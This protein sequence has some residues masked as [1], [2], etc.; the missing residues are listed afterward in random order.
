MKNPPVLAGRF[1]GLLTLATLAT[2]ALVGPA[3]RALAD[4]ELWTGLPGTSVTTNWSDPLNFSGTSKNPNNNTVYF[5]NG[6][7]VAAGVINNVVDKSTNCYAL[8]FTNSTG[9][10]NTLI[11]AGQTLTLDGNNGGPALTFIPG[12][13]TSNTN[14]ISGATGTLLIT[15]SSAGGVTVVTTNSGAAGVAPILDLSGLGTL[16]ISNADTSAALAVG[17]GTVRSGG[18]LKLAQTNYLVLPAVGSVEGNASAIVVGYNSSN[19]GSSPG[20]QLLLGQANQI[21]AGNLGIG[22]SKQGTAILAFNPAFTNNNPTLTLRAVGGGAVTNWA[23]ADGINTSGTSTGPGGTVSFVG[24]TVNALVNA[25][26]LAKPS[27]TSA[28]A[29]SATGSLSFGAGLINVNLLTNGCAQAPTTGGPGKATATI[30]VN[31][32]GSL[33]VNNNL[34][35]AYLAT[36]A[37]SST[38]TLNIS[39]NGVVQANAITP[40]GGNST[41]NLVG[42]ILIVSNSLG[43]AAAPLT[44][45][46]LSNSILTF[47]V[48]NGTASA[49]V[50]TLNINGTAD[51]LNIAA[52]PVTAAFPA[53]YPVIQY[54]GGFGGQTATYD[55][56]LGTLP[57]TYQGY[58]S[59]NVANASVDLVVTNATQKLDTWNGNVNGNWDATTLN[60]LYSGN[61]VNYQA[62]D[63]VSFSD[64]AAGTPNVVLTTNLAPGDIAANNSAKNYVFSGPGELSGPTSLAKNGTGSL[65]LAETG[66][67]SFTGGIVVNNGTLVLDDTGST[68]SGGLTLNGGTV[69][70]GNNDANG[71]LP[72]G[73]V[74][75]NGALIFNQTSTS[76]ISALITGSGTLTQNGTGVLTLASP[77]GY[78][79][80]T[81]LARGTLALSGAATLASSA[82]VLVSNATLDVSAL[83]GQTTV[84]NGLTITNAAFNVAVAGLQP[85]LNVLSTLNADGI[86]SVSN[87]INVLS[88][89]P[90]ASY[91]VTLTIIQS[92]GINLA[93]G[94]FNFILGSLPAGS[95]AYAG[96]IVAS[97]DGTAVQLTLTGG[98]VGARATTTW[99][100]VDALA[101]LNTNWT[102]AANWQFPG[103]PAPSDNVIFND[104]ASASSSPF[105]AVGA[106]PGGIANQGGINNIVNA[107]FSISTLT[108]SNINN[109][110]QNTY[111]N[112]GLAL[113]IT[114]SLTVGS[115]TVDFGAG[116]LGFVT[117]AGPN[118]ALNVNNTNSTLY[119]GLGSTSS[120]SHQATLD[121]SG[122]AVFNGELSRLLV[123]VGSSSE[124]YPEARESG[125]LYLAQTNVI[126]A[127][128]AASGSESGDTGA[129]AIS[130]DVGDNDGN[131]GA[132]CFLYLGQ[133]N[134]IYADAIAL[135]RQK[136]TG[137]LLFNPA[138]TSWSAWFRGQNGVSAVATWSIGDGVANSGTTTCTGT[139]DFTGGYVNAL[140]STLYLGRGANNT[141][142]AGTSTGT[143]TFDTG[144]FNVA[145][146]YAGYQPANSSK[147]GIGTIN[148]NTNTTLGANATLIV[149]G[150]LYLGDSTGGSGAAA[151]AGT[152][153]ISGGTVQAGSIVTG[154][155][156]GTST[157][158]LN[159]GTLAITGT[160]GT[161]AAPLTTLALGGGTLQLNLDGA[162]GVTNLVATTINATATTALV[163]GSISGVT[164]SGT[165]PLL[166]YTGTDPYSSLTLQPLPIGYVGTL[167]DDPT[168]GLVSAQFTT[169]PNPLPVHLTGIS[170]TGTTLNLQGTNG[171]PN[172]QYI[173][174][175]ATNLATP[176]SQWVPL[177]TN[178]FNASGDLNL[179]TNIVNPA[180]P[181][182]FY[183]IEQ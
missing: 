62:G 95:P 80:N 6:A 141:T 182:E 49:V 35:I 41:I 60:W 91:P 105:S 38:G 117:I 54:S 127:A 151:T 93:N 15:G 5:G 29:P 82:S 135:G 149:S 107:S 7:L 110:Y 72:A 114:N 94:N 36:G 144:I 126:T 28:T 139:A 84:L 103:A 9:Y 165:Y 31:G 133:T 8:T 125:I 167:V 178:T 20:G 160:A 85:P 77:T 157:V 96:S 120:G 14:T 59:N 23:I 147:I 115:G 143:L 145:T 24:G 37:S 113:T 172:G 90:L 130:L 101:N 12:A 109:D 4:N 53:Q 179:T 119:V 155:N 92:T 170:L 134:A 13:Q 129:S 32:P 116:A 175:G 63:F 166:S 65:T 25:L 156:G 69:Q 10:N 47:A 27:Q 30:N 171:L 50:S 42:G 161:P 51:T 64:S 34:E 111:V 100:G 112:A 56:L 57:G 16:I 83:A 33:V 55:F 39:S 174:L 138:F 40:G 61:P 88:L 11:A 46:S 26:W 180:Q 108:Y 43:S 18:I 153:N 150:T 21:F 152:L 75:D 104:V 71:T 3:P 19:N 22:L 118:G 128:L 142:G 131:G 1:N 121:L 137:S 97:P 173:L 168:D 98:P 79:G 162:A 176:L 177:L 163:L 2:L 169:V 136:T 76:T 70:I 74:T 87:R 140:V 68:I 154:L 158:N 86:V 164:T 99:V 159:A 132:A 44:T 17:V 102:D 123:G 66:G 146:L 106:G 122:L 48:V 181:L 89:P 148:V 73:G 81:I 78:T 67:D 183:R 124:G 45:L 58:L 52:L